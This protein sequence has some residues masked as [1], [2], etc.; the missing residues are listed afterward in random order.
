MTQHPSL[1]RR[2]REVMNIV[3]ELGSATAAQI[4]ERMPDPPSNAAVRS[5][6]RILVERGHL[7]Y[8]QDG[9]RYVYSPTVPIQRTRSS[10][11]RQVLRVFFGGSVEGAMAALI[12]ME[13]SKL[14]E[15]E[16]ERMRTMIERAQKEGR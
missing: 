9:P 11:L 5:V 4:Q 12:D 13:E 10:A 15:E 7:G 16:R 3:H 1:T 14:T 2:E 8:E 6:L